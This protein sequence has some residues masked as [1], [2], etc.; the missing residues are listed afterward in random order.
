VNIALLDRLK[1]AGGFV[2]IEGL[3]ASPADLDELESFGFQFERSEERGIAY[4]VPSPR[5]CPDQIEWDLGTKVIGRRI[6]VWNRV[7]STN[8]LAARAAAS[9]TNDGLVFLA[10]EQ[11]SGRGSRGRKW[12]APAGSSILMSCLLF[13]PIPLQDPGWLTSFA[14]V[15]VAE[16]IAEL[17]LMMRGEPIKARI[18]WPNDIWF[19]GR[20]LGG[21]LVERGQGTVI[22]IG[23]NVNLRPEDFP[24]EL[25]ETATSL[26]AVVG[27]TIDRSE[28]VRLILRQLDRA[29]DSS[30]RRGPDDLGSLY[31]RR[32]AHYW[33]EVD[34]STPSGIVRGRLGKIDLRMGLEVGLSH[35]DSRKISLKDV[36]GIV[37]RPGSVRWTWDEYQ[38]RWWHASS[39]QVYRGRVDETRGVDTG[40]R[41]ADDFEG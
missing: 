15:A 5:L 28:L 11:T 20:K 27:R 10:E 14:A 35:D 25:R 34:V 8:D 22:G 23:L 33:H 41:L 39:D 26:Q 1:R 4:R 32:S 31:E 3:G 19:E 17:G 12:S 37:N 30:I 18:K 24:E 36:L 2:P 29:Y 7:G 13:P 21:I 9:S 16:A 6:A 38:A 40:A